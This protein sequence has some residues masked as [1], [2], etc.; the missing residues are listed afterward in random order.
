MR[1]K[2]DSNININDFRNF[3]WLKKELVFFCQQ[4]KISSY[5]SKID[6]TERICTFL[7]TGEVTR[8]RTIKKKK[9]E[10]QVLDEINLETKIPENIV[11]TKQLKDYFISI[12]GAKF[13][14]KKGLIKF[15]RENPGKTFRDVVYV[16]E[17][18]MRKEKERKKIKKEIPSQC[19]YNQYI[20]DFM[21]GNNGKTLKDAIK[22]WNYKKKLPGHNRYEEEDL[23]CITI[24]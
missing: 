24:N 22:C 8:I 5:G 6:L 17:E 12:C 19:E 2:L 11:F 1:P 18:E 14:F 3:Y 21:A 7:E 16:W 10:K 9:H 20:R 15:C 4:N 23:V 13:R